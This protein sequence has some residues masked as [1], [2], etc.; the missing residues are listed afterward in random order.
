MIEMKKKNVKDGRMEKL[1]TD[2]ISRGERKHIVHVY[3]I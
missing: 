2:N 1:T 3:I